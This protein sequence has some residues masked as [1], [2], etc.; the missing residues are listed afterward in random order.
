MFKAFIS[1]FFK[2][3]KGFTLVEVLVVAV[4]IVFMTGIV[5]ANYRTGGQNLA[6]QRSAQKFAQD[7]RIAQEMAMAASKCQE[8]GNIV[9][10]RYGIFI[11]HPGDKPTSYTLFADRNNDGFFWQPDGDEII[12]GSNINFENGVYLDALGALGCIL[13]APGLRRSHITFKPPDP[14]TEL[15]IIQPPT[16]SPIICSELSLT[17]KIDNL[18]QSRTIKINKSGLIYVE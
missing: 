12:G 7:I 10:S 16:G 4:I 3:R 15:I 9:P 13:P 17:L 5:F 6:L 14:E 2:E 11:M 1:R 8:C 18:D